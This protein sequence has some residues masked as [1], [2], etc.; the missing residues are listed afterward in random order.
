MFTNKEGVSLYGRE[1]FFT[2]KERPSP[3]EKGVSFYTKICN[4]FYTLP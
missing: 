3:I 4:L 1:A 2:S